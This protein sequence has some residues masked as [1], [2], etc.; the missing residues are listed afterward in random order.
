MILAPG[1]ILV[2]ITLKYL[3]KPWHE[4]AGADLLGC[5]QGH[6]ELMRETFQSL[7]LLAQ[8]VSDHP[9]AELKWEVVDSS[10]D[11]IFLKVPEGLGMRMVFAGPCRDFNSA[12][13]CHFVKVQPPGVVPRYCAYP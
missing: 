6:A 3:K 9:P 12:V 1:T 8:I 2:K 5:L 7:D 11:S 4:A 10:E 13:L